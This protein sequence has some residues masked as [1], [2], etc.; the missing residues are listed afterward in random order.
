[1]DNSDDLSDN[2]G[3]KFI[4]KGKVSLSPEGVK[5]ASL[6]T[7]PKGTVLL[8]SR[9]PV[10]YMAIARSDVTTNQGFKSF[11]PDNG[12]STPY[13]Y[14]TLS[15]FMPTIINNASGSTFKEISATTLKTVNVWLPPNP[16]IEKFTNQVEPIF[17]RQD[18][19]ELEN[20][21]LIE[22]RDFLL[23]LLMNGR[24]RIN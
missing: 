21:R 5:S 2:V 11:V 19:I 7:M 6:K 22:T 17:R 9:A 1:M 12:Y 18:L 4:S 14:Y 13:I 10:G 15:T 8:T 3:K 23:P 20:E 24:I 16:L